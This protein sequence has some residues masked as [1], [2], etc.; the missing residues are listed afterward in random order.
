MTLPQT[1]RKLVS[2]R[3]ASTLREATEILEV[4]LQP[5]A[6]NE[7]V[8]R[9]RYSGVNA[10]DYLMAL[11]RYLAPTPPPH[12]LGAESVGEVV[13][14]GENV[15][16]FR[17]GDPVFA[18]GGGFREYFT[19]AANRVFPIPRLS[20]DLITLGVSGLTASIAL[21]KAG[22]MTSGETVLVTAAAGGTGN[23]AVQLAKLAGNHVIGTCS[24][25]DK[26]GFL[27]SIGCDRPINYHTE[28][29]A[30]VLK[31]EYPK[32]VDIVFESVGG[33]QYDTALNALA[34]RGRLIVIGAI[35]EYESGPQEVT[36]V[37]DSYRILSKSASIRGFW[38]M[39]YLREAPA[40]MARLLALLEAGTLHAVI[41]PA[42]FHGVSAALD[43]IEYMYSGKNVG[44]VVVAFD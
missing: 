40:H 11:G 38:L 34:V 20:A 1:Y 44:K 37:R 27:R 14:L 10:A 18:I 36:R 22:E 32:G 9:T 33:K 8:V 23:F 2:V 6:A 21:E 24:S 26:A 43:A 4:P 5:P 30:E 31:A 35:S 19:I 13:M 17:I 25:D 16:D 12:D 7:I 39:H 29:L 42:R 15:Q 41:D 3:A 28:S